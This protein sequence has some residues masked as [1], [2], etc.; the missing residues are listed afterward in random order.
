MGAC[1]SL[2]CLAFAGTLF[3]LFGLPLSSLCIRIS[4]CLTEPV[5]L[6]LVIVSRDLLFSEE[7]MKKSVGMECWK[8][9]KK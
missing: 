1:A 8:N 2:A 4:P 7:E 3:L 9:L 6:G 5:L